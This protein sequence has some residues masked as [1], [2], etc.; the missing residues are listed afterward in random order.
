MRKA[1][2]GALC[3]TLAG[4]LALAAISGGATRT[5]VAAL[6]GADGRA[7]AQQRATDTYKGKFK[8][9]GRR[10]TI[11]IKAKVKHG[12]AKAV[13]EIIYSRLP[14]NCP[15][16]GLPLIGGSWGLRGVRVNDQRKFKIV[17]ESADGRSSL[18]FSGKFSADFEKVRGRFQ[19]DSYFPASGPPQNLPEETCTSFTKR[20]GAK[21]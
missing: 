11:K 1:F 10:A 17:G 15:E 4:G 2:G 5:S 13:R 21:R 9:A 19:T 20:Y 14:A 7:A 6:D 18:R 16:S 8:A 3:A 12:E